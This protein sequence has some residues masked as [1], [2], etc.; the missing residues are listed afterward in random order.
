M[1]FADLSGFTTL[2]EQLTLS[3]PSGVEELSR[4]LNITFSQLLDIIK[5][6]GGDVIKFAGDALLAIWPAEREGMAGAVLRAAQCALGIQKRISNFYRLISNSPLYLRIVV[7]GGPLS[8]L[9]IG[10]AYGRWEFLATGAPLVD[11]ALA[12]QLARPG[13][14]VVAEAAWHFISG[15][16]SGERRCFAEKDCPGIRLI[17][18]HSAV[19]P[20][21]RQRPSLSPAIEPALRAYVPGAVMNRLVAGQTDWLADLRRITVIFVNLPDLNH[22]TP[23]ELAQTAMR[24]LQQLLYRYEGSINKLS[25]DDKGATLVAAMGLPPLSHIDDPARG[26]QAAL[27]MQQVLNELN[28]RSAI[29]ITTGRAFCGEIG[30]DERREYTMIG[31]VVNLAARLMQAAASL[32]GVG[33]AG[34]SILCDAATRQSFSTMPANPA[35]AFETLD[36]ITVKGKAEAIPIFRPFIDAVHASPQNDVQPPEPDLLEP[37]GRRRERHILDQQIVT[38]QHDGPGGAILIEA[39]AG[40]GKSHLVQYT[41]SKAEAHRITAFIG[42][43]DATEQATPYY[44]WRGIFSRLLDL[45]VLSSV[46]DRRTHILSLLEDEPEVLQLAPLL[47]TVLL[48]DLPDNEITGQLSGKSRADAT[49]NLLLRMIADSA[50]RSP[51]LLILEDA[52]WMDSASWALALAIVQRVRNVLLIATM[53]PMAGSGAPRPGDSIPPEYHRFRRQALAVHMD[54]LSA[55]EGVELVCRRLGVADLPEP[56]AEFIRERAQGNP[57]YSEALAFA[58]R[59]TGLIQIV[60]DSCVLAPGADLQR[61][62][63]PETVQ[64]AIISRIDRLTPTQQLALKVASVFGRVFPYSALQAIFP[65]DIA[66][67]HLSDDLDTLARLDI[68]VPDGREPEPVYSFKHAIIQ[69]VVYD[70]MLFS[71]RRQLHRAAAEWYERHY[72]GSSHEQ[73]EVD[74]E[75]DDNGHQPAGQESA[76]APYYSLLAYHWR[77]AG[78]VPRALTYLEQAGRHALRISALQDARAMFEQALDLLESADE[79]YVAHPVRWRI[80]LNRLAGEACQHLGDMGAAR[81]YFNASLSLA[82]STHN[83]I[84]EIAALSRIGRMLIE[85]GDYGGAQEVLSTA[86]QLARASTAPSWLADVLVNLGVLAFRKGSLQEADASFQESMLL[87]SQLGD[88]LAV[89]YV[90]SNLGDVATARGAFGEAR[91]CYEESLQTRRALGHRWGVAN[92]LWNLGRLA[93]LEGCP[94]PALTLLDESF[95]MFNDIGDQRGLVLTMIS[96]GACMQALDE[97]QQAWHIFAEALGV[98][99]TMGSLTLTLESLLALLDLHIAAE[100]YEQATELFGFAAAASFSPALQDRLQKLRHCLKQHL[101]PAAYAAAVARGQSLSVGEMVE[102][103]QQLD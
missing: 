68:T 18:I 39:E 16:C 46:D 9:H 42:A 77:Q 62:S 98:A 69:E 14:V 35:P 63:F 43:A 15:R 3:G 37:V 59:D 2:A 56:I 32:P 96:R 81:R 7:A 26:V 38:L 70:L 48:L 67:D 64:G 52:H 12:E 10:G 29:G 23:V 66:A 82:R 78:I 34:C 61:L 45:D 6:H 55:E 25:L 57:L 44:T 5:A 97:P 87:A 60:G 99:Y 84:A 22:N 27:A 41:R 73:V 76:L 54:A 74:I 21:P 94:R 1:L 17:E 49:R 51:K 86:L 95:A 50:A 100:R 71:Q 58:L 83:Q 33:S 31:D 103:I 65:T 91:Y 89:A 47:N 8:L 13:D 80:S 88:R 24:S 40:F 92:A 28:F 79:A 36:P 30:S 85:A 102:R 93:L 53:R 90:L 19:P 4:I 75:H 20:Q 101:P 11:L 72:G